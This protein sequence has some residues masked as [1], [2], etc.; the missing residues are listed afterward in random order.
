MFI[1]T[2]CNRIYRRVNIAETGFILYKTE[3]VAIAIRISG[4]SFVYVLDIIYDNIV[5][6][7]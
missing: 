1:G 5:C 4:C 2:D 7:K 6:H 3:A